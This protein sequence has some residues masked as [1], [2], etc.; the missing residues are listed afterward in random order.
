[1]NICADCARLTSR[2]ITASK[3]A[4]LRCF[5]CE[6]ARNP[7]PLPPRL[8]RHRARRRMADAIKRRA[9]GARQIRR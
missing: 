3:T 2:G 9:R 5:V 8:E 7:P 4:R 1:M 6:V